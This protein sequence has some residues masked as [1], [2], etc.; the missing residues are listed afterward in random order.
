MS[1]ISLSFRAHTFAREASMLGHASAHS[2]SE[3]DLFI[4][5]FITGGGGW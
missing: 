4:R 5:L 1:T 3:H 2:H